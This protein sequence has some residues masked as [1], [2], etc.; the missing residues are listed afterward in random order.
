MKIPFYKRILSFLYP[1][2]IEKQ[3]DFLQHEHRVDLY[4]NQLLLSTSNAIYSYGTTYY[5]FD[6]PFRKIKKELPQVNRFLMLGTALGSGLKILQKKYNVFPRSVLVDINPL[7]LDMS[8]KYMDLNQQQNV[9]WH[10]AEAEFFIERCEAKFDL[11]GVDIFIDMN[12]PLFVKSEDFMKKVKRLLL[13][14]GKVIFNLVFNSTN[15]KQIIENRLS[16]VFN[17]VIPIPHDR[18]QFYICQD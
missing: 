15:E 8:K 13:P 1:Q 17:N 16:T 4:K 2:L 14:G 7:M 10:C 5:P 18:N 3:V 11:I 6:I 9:E 12:V